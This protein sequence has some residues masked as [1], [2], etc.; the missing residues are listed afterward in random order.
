M[1]D[2]HDIPV[3]EQRFTQPDGWRWH[4]FERNGRKIRFGSVSP[5][6]SVPDG[7]VVCLQG[8]REFSE[9]YYE[10]ARWCLD[11][12]L[13]FWIMD[14]MGQGKSG[15]YIAQNPQK[16]HSVDFNEDVADLHY[17]IQEYVKGASV[18]PDRGRIPMVMLAHSM[19]ANIGLR[20]IAKHT[21]VFECAAFTAPLIGIK[22]FRFIPQHF[23][24]MVAG[25]CSALFGRSYIPGGNDFE[26][27]DEHARLSSDAAR[28]AVQV[29]W[30]QHDPELACGDVTFGWV[31]AAQ[32]SCL[33]LQKASF[34]HAIS[35]PCVFAISGY[36][37]LVD[38]AKSSKAAQYMK[39][40]KV[41]DYP[42]SAH[43]ILM[44]SDEIRDD[45]LAQFYTLIK[46]NLID[47]PKALK[48]F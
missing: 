34:M 48:R 22:A 42:R 24:L 17:F 18:H 46:E 21:N 30:Q 13:S 3:L 26:K 25:M 41:V 8:V 2:S 40:C 7:V 32:K 9:K 1:G 5:K 20:Y 10:I 37:D 35:I 36:E 44:E 27:R 11:H 6:N 33:V 31:Y 38:N 23:I 47:S 29:Q 16:R 28:L 4:G 45:F 14:W 43:E 12:N 15:R 19:G 39:S